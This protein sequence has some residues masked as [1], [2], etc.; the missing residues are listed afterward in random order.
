[1]PTYLERIREKKRREAQQA[2]LGLAPGQEEAE[3]D[4]LDDLYGGALTGVS[5]AADTADT[6]GNWIREMLV[7]NNPFGHTFDPGKRVTGKDLWRHWTGED[8][9]FWGGMAVEIATDPLT[10]LTGGLG[11]IGKA[12]KI[13]KGAGLISK[14]DDLVRIAAKKALKFK[15]ADDLGDLAKV[16]TTALDK[17]H[18]K[19]WV[20]LGEELSGGGVGIGPRRARDMLSPRDLITYAD[21]PGIAGGAFDRSMEAL[22]IKKKMGKN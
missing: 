14:S 10:Y 4:L 17:K 15:N 9:G 5:Y 8:S 18:S 16:A 7:G 19:Q 22:A 21:D 12:G 13:A 2:V 20:K 3:Q 6:P 11:A 1:M